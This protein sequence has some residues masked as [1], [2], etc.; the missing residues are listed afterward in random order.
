MSTLADYIYESLKAWLPLADTGEPITLR[1]LSARFDVSTM[2]VRQAVERLVRKGLLTRQ[3]GRLVIVPTRRARRRASRPVAPQR[4]RPIFERILHELIPQ[5]FQGP[6]R[7]SEEA[8]A[9]RFGVSR[10]AIRQALFQFAGMGIVEHRPRHG[11]GLLAFDFDRMQDF[12]QAREAFE[13][14]ALELAKDRLDEGRLRKFLAR[15]VL[16]EGT[17]P[18][19]TDNGFHA[20]LVER[21]GNAYIRTFFKQFGPYYALLFEWEGQDRASEIE[22]CRQHRAILQS[23]I[24]RDWDA[25]RQHLSDHILHNHRVLSRRRFRTLSRRA[26]RGAG[27]RSRESTD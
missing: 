5:T 3:K 24:R 13:L 11:W 16:P 26:S 25:A 1:G 23:L 17:G 9:S 2:P 4:P 27:R 20:Y 7:L 14:K 18:A 6:R 21:S 15:N 12:L 10:S 19:Q 8:L 22:A